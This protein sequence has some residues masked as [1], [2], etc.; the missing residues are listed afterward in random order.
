MQIGPT[1]PVGVIANEPT[2]IMATVNAGVTPASFSATSP[3][4]IPTSGKRLVAHTG[5]PADYGFTLIH[6]VVVDFAQYA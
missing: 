3:A 5:D 1:V 4:A 2:P 6:A